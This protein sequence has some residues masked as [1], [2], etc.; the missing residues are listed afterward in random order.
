MIHKKTLKK[1]FLPLL[2]G[3]TLCGRAA[4][5]ALCIVAAGDVMLGSWAE[6]T[7]LREG[8][9]YPFRALDTLLNDGHLVAANLEAPLG[10]KGEAFEKSYTF[11][12]H[13]DLVRTLKAGGINLVSLA[14]NHVP[15]F[16]P[17]VLAQTRE[18]LSENGIAF[19]GAGENLTIARQP[20]RL[21]VNGRKIVFAAYSLTFPKEFWATDSSAGT[22]FPFDTFLYDDI[23]SFKNEADLL[24]VSYHWGGELQTTPRD[25]QVELAHRTLDAGADIILGHH[26]HIVQGIEIYKGKLIAYS[27]GNFV[28]GSYS[29]NVRDSM[30]LKIYWGTNG[31]SK[32]K[33][34]P[35]DVYNR[36]VEFQPRPLKG[37]RRTHFLAQLRELSLELNQ[38]GD[39]IAKDGWICF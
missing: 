17:A 37:E 35:I 2:L 34:V 28:F 14:N 8:W 10:N 5:D 9:N 3:L 39:V 15:D 6:E 31:D 12:V 36:E 16:G 38:E 29:E 30:L 18:L 27:L 11:R 32:C 26:P 33:I 13:P 4:D 22:C 25:Y 23:R 1:I 19:A 21:E 20:A 24:L 7:I